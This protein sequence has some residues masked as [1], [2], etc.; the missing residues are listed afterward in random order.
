MREKLKK[1]LVDK[2]E[3]VETKGVQGIGYSFAIASG[4]AGAVCLLN[5]LYFL[6]NGLRPEGND[7]FCLIVSA[8]F[9]FLSAAAISLSIYIFNLG[10][11]MPPIAPI[12]PQNAKQL[13]EIETLVRASN[14]PPSHQQAELLRATSQGSETPPEEL[15]RAT[16]KDTNG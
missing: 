5:S 8:V 1:R 9:G 2:Q 11:K 12:T 7:A 3:Y 16:L 4:S 15:L 10:R 13:P 14:L 6:M